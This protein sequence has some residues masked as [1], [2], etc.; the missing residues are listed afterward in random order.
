MAASSG[1]AEQKGLSYCWVPM[2]SKHTINAIL[3]MVPHTVAKI[4][5]GDSSMP[6]GY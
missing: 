6:F 5:I 1:D 4:A 2:S 3:P